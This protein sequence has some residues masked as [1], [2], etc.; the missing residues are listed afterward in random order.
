[1]MSE[2]I[3]ATAFAAPKLTERQFTMI[4]DLIFKVCGINLHDGKEGLVQSRLARQLRKLGLADFDEYFDHVQADVSGRALSDMVDAL[5]TN[6][7]SFFR[8]SRHFD[9][10]RDELLPGLVRQ[11]RIRIWSAGCSSG[12][13]PYTIAMLLRQALPA[14]GGPDARIL[15]TDLATPVLAKAREGVYEEGAVA[16]VPE[17]FA[18]TA[19]ECV[20]REPPRLYRVNDDVR[21]LVQFARLN[22]MD[23]WPM[24][25]P[26]D[27]IFCRN[28]M[29]YFTK[30]TQEQLIARY[31]D[32]LA[33]GGYLFVG[34]SESLSGIRHSFRYLQPAVYVK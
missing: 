12:E 17:P 21:A 4:R 22:L 34:H 6:K 2:Q 1:M 24:R 16:D 15:A 10:L 3:A 23:D 9:L 5:T 14:A 29:I 27:V 26:M 25:G 18:R 32:L 7:T 13:E 28:V 31:H 30:E 20:R 33:P 11:R 8:E 19:F